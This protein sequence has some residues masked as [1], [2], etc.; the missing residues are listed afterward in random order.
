MAQGVVT[1][2]TAAMFQ[3]DG[4]EAAR[5]LGDAHRQLLSDNSIQFE[6]PTAGFDPSAQQFR[7]GTGP[8]PNL[9]PSSVP[10]QSPPP[11]LPTDA[12]PP[13]PA[14]APDIP[15]PSGGN[16]GVDG[17]MQIFL[18]VAAAIALAILLFWIFSFFR[19]RQFGAREPRGKKQRGGRGDEV[20]RPEEEQAVQLLDEADVLAAEGRYD[21]AARLLLHRSIGEIDAHRPDLVRPAL[22][23]RDIARHPL[24]PAGPATAFARIAALVERSLFARRPLGPDDWQDCRTAYRE[25]AFPQGWQG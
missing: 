8:S 13:Q 16:A 15:V 25:F 17:F 19:D 20:W 9:N 10:P 12:P 6:L 24:L 3:E 5:Q 22:T 14:P 18:W 2:M 7:P 4:G 11:R 23:S 21:E 1:S